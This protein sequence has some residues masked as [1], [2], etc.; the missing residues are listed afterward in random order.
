MAE[1][2]SR[3]HAPSSAHYPIAPL[4]RFTLVGLYLALVLPL[5]MLAPPELS[6]WMWGGLVVGLILIAAMLSEQV[7]LGPDSIAVGYPRWCAWLIRRGWRLNWS[8]IASLVPITTSQGGTVYYV[9]CTQGKHVLLPQR[10]DRFSDFLQRFQQA[11]GVDTKGIGR[12][13]PL[14][15]YWT[16][17]GLSLLLLVGEAA[18][19]AR[20]LLLLVS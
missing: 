6:I 8:E 5:P 18:A 4:I 10:L 9:R 3:Q 15:T 16:L 1:A 13:T 2:G 12:I 7:V 17:A 19:V 20:P 11:S 14:W